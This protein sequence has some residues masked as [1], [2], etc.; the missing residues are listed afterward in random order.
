MRGHRVVWIVV[1]AAIVLVL[2]GAGVA[3]AV[4][5]HGR[6][7]TPAAAGPAAAPSPSPSPSGPPAGADITGPLDLLLIGVDTRTSPGWEPHADAVMLLHVNAGLDSGYLY[8][9]PRDLRVDMPADAKAGFPGGRY[10][11]T[12]AMSYGARV[13]GSKQISV[14]QG[15][16]L[17]SSTIS[18]YTGIKTFAAGAV[19]NFA[20]LSKLTD[21]LGGVTLYVDEKVV[22]HHR[23]PDGSLRTLKPGG[24]DYTGPQAVYLP[25]TRKLVGWQALDYARQ[26]YGLKNGD[27]DRQRHQRQLVKALLG[28][29]DAAGLATDTAKLQSVLGA[30]GDTLVYLGG[31]R[32]VEYAYALRN[33]KPESLTMVGLP[34]DGV[35][36]GGRYLGEQL[37]PV[38]RGFLTAVAEG[39]PA[40]YLTAHPELINKR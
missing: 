22:S 13:A 19:L 23:K 28:E 40:A 38:G 10:K 12:E 18:A 5:R 32:P 8:S 3:A 21:A 1:A 37:T 33:L 17:L 35:S 2:A 7:G 4:T 39:D 26:R 36:S 27:Y 30:L 20:G 9:L 16:A 31:R 15:Y 29:A 14:P 25:G 34:G 11:L 24:G 6:A